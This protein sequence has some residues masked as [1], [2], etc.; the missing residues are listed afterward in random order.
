MVS[1]CQCSVYG[2]VFVDSSGAWRGLRGANLLAVVP[3]HSVIEIY[4]HEINFREA[5]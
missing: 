2:S 4:S 3:M 5:Y 1:L